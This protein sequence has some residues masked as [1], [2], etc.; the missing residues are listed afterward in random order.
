MSAPLWQRLAEGGYALVLNLYPR[1]TRERH[2]EEMRQ[3][4]RDRC[5]EVSDGHI[6]A[7]RLLGVEL[8]PDLATS[9]A[10]AHLEEPFMPRIRIAIVGF[11]LLAC[12]WFFQDA[13]S[14]QFLDVYFKAGLHYQNWKE[15]RAFARDAAQVSVL[16][17]RFGSQPGERERSL[18]AYLY[19]NNYRAHGR[20][21][22]YFPG[23]FETLPFDPPVEEHARAMQLLASLKNSTDA[24]T[25]RTALATCRMLSGCDRAAH[26]QALV[27]LEP[28]NAYAWSELLKL[29]SRAGDQAAVRA[30]L[31]RVGA[32]RYYDDGVQRTDQAVWAAAVATYGD[33]AES[34]G[35]LGR[36]LLSAGASVD[37]DYVNGVMSLCRLS[38]VYPR[39]LDRNP[40]MWPACERAAMVFGNSNDV[41]AARWGSF[42]LD[43]AHPSERT[44]A[45][46]KAAEARVQA[47]GTIGGNVTP[48][49]RYNYWTPWTDAEWKAWATSQKD[50]H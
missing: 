27:R 19:A 17:D 47:L 44:R 1:R 12:A 25:V 50:F 38:S 37:D 41:F 22:T 11:A 32:S 26:V 21:A 28:G 36:Q 15:S 24:A 3:V 23:A 40:A 10:G 35:A 14:K 4:F 7:W 20:E 8:A 48:G 29:H 16:A 39:W 42:W 33:N 43:R 45:G 30:D 5:R 9:L 49:D 6:S 46:Q 34:F 18:A 13:I 31:E 2:G